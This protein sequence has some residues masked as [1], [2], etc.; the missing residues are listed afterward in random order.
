[1]LLENSFGLSRDD[2]PVG[3]LGP[4]LP[5]G[6][7]PGSEDKRQRVV[8]PLAAG[9]L[10]AGLVVDAGIMNLLLASARTPAP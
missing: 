10:D 8:P 4:H 1:M 5:P 7:G 6:E 3:A 2:A 9:V